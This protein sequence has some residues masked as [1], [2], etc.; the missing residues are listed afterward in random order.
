MNINFE[1]GYPKVAL[2]NILTKEG[3]TIYINLSAVESVS[4]NRDRSTLTI[5]YVNDKIDIIAVDTHIL[6]DVERQ[7]NSILGATQYTAEVSKHIA[8]Y[9][10]ERRL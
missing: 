6:K 1:V 3:N 4:I 2:I 5:T 10:K 9:T 8:F 7:L